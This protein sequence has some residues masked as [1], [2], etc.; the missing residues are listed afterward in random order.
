[1]EN[2]IA[3]IESIRMRMEA[4]AQDLEKEVWRVLAREAKTR[5][6]RSPR[7]VY[8]SLC[9]SCGNIAYTAAKI[10]PKRDL[11][12]DAI[13]DFLSEAIPALTY[14]PECGRYFGIPMAYFVCWESRLKKK[15]NGK[16]PAR[17]VLF[18][19]TFSSTGKSW[20]S[21]ARIYGETPRRR[22]GRSRRTSKTIP[23][24][25]EFPNLGEI[26]QKFAD[27]LETGDRRASEYII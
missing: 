16:E 12:G 23:I 2:T 10:I 5:R 11:W 22:I 13:C 1:M 15:N 17:N 18:I 26:V 6:I 8:F 4:L 14:C 20:V 7:I 19:A 27:Y 3:L 24:V 25:S 9:L 21:A